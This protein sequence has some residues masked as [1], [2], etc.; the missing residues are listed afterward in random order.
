MI[1]QQI[2]DMERNYEQKK[3]LRSKGEEMNLL[4]GDTQRLH[5]VKDDNENQLSSPGNAHHSTEND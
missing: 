4:T 5:L 3:L 1:K 2:S